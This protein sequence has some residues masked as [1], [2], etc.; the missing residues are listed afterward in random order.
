MFSDQRFTIVD[1]KQILRVS[2]SRPLTEE[3]LRKCSYLTSTLVLARNKYSCFGGFVESSIIS[4][5]TI[6]KAFLFELKHNVIFQAR[7]RSTR[8]KADIYCG[9]QFGNDLGINFPNGWNKFRHYTGSYCSEPYK[10]GYDLA[11]LFGGAEI[12]KLD[13]FEV[14]ELKFKQWRPFHND[15]DVSQIWCSEHNVFMDFNWLISPKWIRL[16]G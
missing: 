1:A 3:G 5:T 11:S 15:Y 12:F 7:D 9:I 10:D 16:H 8:I 13:C 14:Y 6:S 2:S 4:E